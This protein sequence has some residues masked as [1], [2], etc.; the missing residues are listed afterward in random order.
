MRSSLRSRA[1][2]LAAAL[3][4]LSAFGAEG[5][6]A[7]PQLPRTFPAAGELVA[8]TTVV[9]ATPGSHARQIAVLRDLRS[10]FRPQIVLA[11][12]LRADASGGLWYRIR[13][14]G[15][16]NGRTGW[17]RAAAA[18][19]SPTVAGIVIR[20]GARTLELYRHGKLELKTRVA[21]GARGMETPLGTFYVTSRFR[22]RNSFLGEYALETSAYSKLSEWPGGGVVGIHGTSRPDLLGRAVSHGCVRV[23][24][25]AALVLKR[26]APL[27]T[28][29][30]IVR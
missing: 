8:R 25:A 13:I 9:R 5:R 26:L 12:E 1:S 7:S 16:P 21:V 3:L 18:R 24:N 6:A 22:P 29:I 2:V 17:I 10:D 15:R 23:A 14:P 20:R 19:L 30:Q 4:A 11:H 27:G 28:P